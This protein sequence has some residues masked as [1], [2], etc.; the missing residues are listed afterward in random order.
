MAPEDV[1]VPRIRV[2]IIED[3]EVDARA[4]KRMLAE[5]PEVPVHLVHAESLEE[6]VA[7][8]K[9]SPAFDVVLLDLGLPESRGLPTLDK[10]R[11][12]T[13]DLPIVVLTSA[14]DR[15]LGIQA[16]QHGAQDYLTKGKVEA[17]LMT[18]AM[19]YAIERHQLHRESERLLGE[20][21]R[22]NAELE[23]FAYVASHD[24]MAPL[25]AVGGYCQLLERRCRDE[26]SQ[27]S[28][29]WM[30]VIVDSAKQ[31][32]VLIE[33]L[34]ALSRVQRRDKP[35]DVVELTSVYNQVLVSLAA[36]IEETS[37][38]VTCDDLPAVKANPTQMMQ[39][40]QNLVGNA[41]KF[42]GDKAPIVHVSA[43]QK[44]GE[45]VFS[46]RDN[47]IG[48]EEKYMDRVFEVFKRL[49]T[50][51]AYPG[52]GIGLA[53]C[54]KIVEVHGGRIWIESK[55]DEGSLFS[56]TIPSDRVTEL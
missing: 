39:L 25:R 13:D 4:V 33:D 36:E 18:R 12:A 29:Q 45:W 49:H 24:L 56:F 26:L 10:F 28:Q 1:T 20:L 41:V 40:L 27:E 46:V 34:L 48:I 37:A 17:E 38:T 52:T 44:S 7:E 47:G 2:L 16:L 22:S 5:I 53:L 43:E 31:M 54:K 35:E 32:Q 11:D 19:T 30:E 21:T 15:Q 9:K 50:Q 51:D 23:Q 42:R 6:G 8:T 14:D 55:M 3:D